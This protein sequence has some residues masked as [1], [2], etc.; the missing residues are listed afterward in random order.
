MEKRL[1]DV[2]EASEYLGVSKYTLY[3]WVSQKMVPYVKM[4]RKTLFDRKRLDD[5]IRENTV[6]TR[7]THRCAIRTEKLQ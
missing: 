7:D 3:D 5:F 2:N 4:G 6:E 1:L